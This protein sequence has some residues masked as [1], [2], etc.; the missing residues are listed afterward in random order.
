MT[1]QAKRHVKLADQTEQRVRLRVIC[2]A[3]PKP[4]NHG[5]EFGLQNN[6][7]TT[8]WVIHAGA[9]QPNG[10]IHFECECR[11][12]PNPRTN[13]PSFLGPFVHGEAAKRFLYL[14]WR[15]KDWRPGQA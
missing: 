14:S 2:I 5:A 3:P 10:D 15:P 11:I 12:R 4:E 13:E 6:S 9:A 8:D 7:T 1:I